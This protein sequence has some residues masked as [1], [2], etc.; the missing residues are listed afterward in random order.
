MRVE[1]NPKTFLGVTIFNSKT[2]EFVAIY[3]ECEPKVI[4]CLNLNCDSVLR[5][6]SQKENK[7]QGNPIL[8][9]FYEAYEKF[10]DYTNHKHDYK[11]IKLHHLS[12]LK[13]EKIEN[14][15]HEM[16]LQNHLHY[17]QEPK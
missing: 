17:F 4:R 3:D 14:Y 5:E 1:L 6:T 13:P 10:G 8:D 16:N 12:N 11:K 15:L 9:V 7:K 2:D